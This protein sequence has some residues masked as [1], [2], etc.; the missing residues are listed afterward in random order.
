MVVR[1]KIATVALLSLTIVLARGQDE[2]QDGRIQ[3]YV[4]LLQPSLWRELDFVRQVC[5]LTPE[6]RPKIKAAADTAVIDAAKAMIQPQRQARSMPTL[7]AQMIHDSVHEAVKKTLTSEQRESYETENAAR[8]AATK[9]ATIQ[10][11]V[12]QLD[13]ALFLT[14]E[15]REKITAALESNWQR[16]WEQW[17]SMYRYNSQYFPQVPDQHVTPYLN[18][19]QKTVWNGLQKVMINAWNNNGR[20]QA[21]DNWWGPDKTAKAKA[22]TAKGKAALLQPAK[23]VK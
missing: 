15:Q 7:A 3:Q 20:R 4:Q 12:S 14:T 5:D 9:Q 1:L 16:D 6:Q 19:E 18:A 11:V 13:G 10:G 2:A 21:D 17:L 8:T 22:L 23:K